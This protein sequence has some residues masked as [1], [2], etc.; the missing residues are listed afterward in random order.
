MDRPRSTDNRV[1]PMTRRE[2]AVR[3]RVH[4]PLASPEA[5]AKEPAAFPATT[6]E[7]PHETGF[8]DWRHR[9]TGN[10]SRRSDGRWTP[11]TWTHAAEPPPEPADD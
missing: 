2:D 5:I 10:L 7:E 4:G 8:T 9:L 11:L 3:H 1:E 6:G